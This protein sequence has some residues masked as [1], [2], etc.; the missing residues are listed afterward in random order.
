LLSRKAKPPAENASMTILTG[1]NGW[2]GLAVAQALADGTAAE[3]G[4][5]VGPTRGLVLKGTNTSAL[6][7]VNAAMQLVEGNAASGE[8]MAELFP[9]DARGGILI[10]TV[11]VIHPRKVTEFYAVNV[12]GTRNVLSSH[13]I[14]RADA[15]RTPT[16]FSTRNLPSTPT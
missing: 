16:I 5:H 13:P 1:A 15:I 4:L 7:S 10:H 6:K 8:G 12:E 14:L 11:G 9:A 2:L 3:I